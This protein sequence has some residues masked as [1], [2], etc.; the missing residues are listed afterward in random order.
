ME[1][2]ILWLLL[3]V[4]AFYFLLV[5]PQRRQMAAMREL[6]ASLGEGDEIVTTSGL[7][8]RV[9]ALDDVSVQLEIAPGTVVRLARGAVGRRLVDDAPGDLPDERGD[10]G[11]DDTAG[12][13]GDED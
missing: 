10:E 7:Y 4:A 6:Q 11:P 9:V 2:A 1:L 12:P 3:L 5:R 8:G 13:S